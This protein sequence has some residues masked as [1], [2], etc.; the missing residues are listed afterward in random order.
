MRN[1]LTGLLSNIMGF[2]ASVIIHMMNIKTSQ[3]TV[4]FAIHLTFGVMSTIFSHTDLFKYQNMT[5]NL[6][7]MTKT[8]SSPYLVGYLKKSLNR[9]F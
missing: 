7:N 5:F 4:V 2:T 1:M 9:H 3:L 8:Q 6:N